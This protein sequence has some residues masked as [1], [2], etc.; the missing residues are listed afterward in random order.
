L[1][2]TAARFRAERERERER[3][4]ERERKQRERKKER[5]KEREKERKK[6]ETEREKEREK[7]RERENYRER[8]RARVYTSVV[9]VCGILLRGR[10]QL[11]GSLRQFGY[12]V[13]AMCLE[14]CTL[15]LFCLHSVA[16]RVSVLQCVGACCS[17]V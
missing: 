15:R 14:V 7:E 4:K 5:E 9:F 17:V 10:A 3:E 13:V 11:V 8:E 6:E 1:R 12:E 16:V 2:Y